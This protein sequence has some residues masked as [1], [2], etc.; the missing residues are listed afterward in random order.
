MLYVIGD[1]HGCF[2]DLIK[3]IDQIEDNSKIIFLGDYI[4]RGPK[5]KEVVDLVKDL[6]NAVPLMGNHEDM[7]IRYFNGYSSSWLH[8][9]N[10]GYATIKSFGSPE[11]VI[12]YLDFFTSLRFLHLEN[13]MGV[14]ILFSHGNINP[15]FPVKEI[16]GIK[17]Y[18]E[19]YEKIQEKLISFNE[20]NIWERN[21][22]EKPTGNYVVVHGHTPFNSVFLNRYKNKIFEINI[23][24]GAVYGGCLTALKIPYTDDEIKKDT[25]IYQISS[26]SKVSS[27]P[28]CSLEDLFRRNNFE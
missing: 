8:P 17:T 24:T 3:I 1:I 28:L 10:G 14:N 20:T 21:I 12:T 25:T 16:L 23:D 27:R 9:N 6:K 4:D 19:Y 26:K 2:D 22:F 7:L 18:D 11:K 15:K 13:I 5:S